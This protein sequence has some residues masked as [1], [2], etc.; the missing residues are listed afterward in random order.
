M[1]FTNAS[2]PFVKYFHYWF[3]LSCLFLLEFL[4][5]FEFSSHFPLFFVELFSFWFH[6]EESIRFRFSFSILFTNYFHS[7]VL[8]K[9]YI[10]F[11]VV[12]IIHAKLLNSFLEYSA[13]QNLNPS[14]LLHLSIILFHWL[15]LQRFQDQVLPLQLVFRFKVYALSYQ[16]SLSIINQTCHKLSVV[17]E[18]GTLRIDKCILPLPNLFSLLNSI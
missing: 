10:L 3:N 6:Q 1:K 15:E 7:F 5:K 17:R 9:L 11:L 2:G 13:F 4:L 12:I 18:H 8:L 14:H 16:I